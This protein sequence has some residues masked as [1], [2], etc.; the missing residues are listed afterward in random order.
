MM[1]LKI[2]DWVEVGLIEIKI[3]TYF[4]MKETRIVT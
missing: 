1:S 2:G 3:R 4:T